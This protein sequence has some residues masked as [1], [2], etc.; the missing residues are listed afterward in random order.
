MHPWLFQCLSLSCSQVDDHVVSQGRKLWGLYNIYKVLLLFLGG[1]SVNMDVLVFCNNTE[2]IILVVFSLLLCLWPSNLLR[3]ILLVLG[4]CWL[5]VLGRV[6]VSSQVAGMKSYPMLVLFFILYLEHLQPP[7]L[8]GENYKCLVSAGLRNCP[9][10]ITGN[11]KYS[12]GGK[13][14]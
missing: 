14:H 3:K 2:V 12:R 1:N 8:L 6:G 5:R 9:F 4:V 11:S 7:C 13:S 10:L